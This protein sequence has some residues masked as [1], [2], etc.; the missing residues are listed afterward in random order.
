MWASYLFPV[1]HESVDADVVDDVPGADDEGLSVLTKQL[2]EV[3]VRVI[4]EEPLH[5]RRR[6]TKTWKEM[7]G[8][9]SES[10]GG[11]AIE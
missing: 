11:S 6:E 2:E 3:R 7:A 4:A 10:E 8:K 1:F 5:G 9:G